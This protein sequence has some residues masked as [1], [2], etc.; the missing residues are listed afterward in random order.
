VVVVAEG[1]LSDLLLCGMRFMNSSNMRLR[2][3]M[4]AFRSFVIFV[5]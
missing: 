2:I 5:H 4:C 1:E 3:F